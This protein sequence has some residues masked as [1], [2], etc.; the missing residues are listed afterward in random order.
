MTKTSCQDCRVL[1]AMSF[2]DRLEAGEATAWWHCQSC[3]AHLERYRGQGDQDCSCG[4]WYNAGGQRLRDDWTSNRSWYDDE[5]GDL[6]GFEL[7][8]LAGEA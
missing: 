6:E 4:A 3:G 7:A 2:E 1:E 8:A 5:V